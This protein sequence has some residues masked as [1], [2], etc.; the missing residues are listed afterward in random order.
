MKKKLFIRNLIKWTVAT[1]IILAVVI[2]GYFTISIDP[3]D[4]PDEMLKQIQQEEGLK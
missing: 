3:S 2:F 4:V 1:L